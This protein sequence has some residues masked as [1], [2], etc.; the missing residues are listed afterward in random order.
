MSRIT[1]S[2]LAMTF[3]VIRRDHAQW[4]HHRCQVARVNFATGRIK[5]RK[6]ASSIP[7]EVGTLIVSA[8]LLAAG[9]VDS[10]PVYAKEVRLHSVVQLAICAP[11]TSQSTMRATRPAADAG[12]NYGPTRSDEI[13]NYA[14]YQRGG[15]N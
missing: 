5:G 7:T 9:A 1:L 2:L 12:R 10:S 8:F 4:N 11:A 14:D 6:K 15:A 13:I 3:P